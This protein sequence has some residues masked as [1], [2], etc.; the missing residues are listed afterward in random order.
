MCVYIILSKVLYFSC[1]SVYVGFIGLTLYLLF[2]SCKS[3][4]PVHCEPIFKLLVSQFLS[5]SY[6]CAGMEQGYFHRKEDPCSHHSVVSWRLKDGKSTKLQ[7][8]PLTI[9]T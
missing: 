9:N 5:M 1:M 4:I 3:N 6:L 7:S 2:L 8:L